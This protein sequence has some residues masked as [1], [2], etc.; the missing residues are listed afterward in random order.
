[1]LPEDYENPVDEQINRIDAWLK[2]TGMKESRLGLLACANARAV[3]R[4]RSGTGSVE[5]LRQLVEYIDAHPLKS[6]KR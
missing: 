3:E 4:V 1:M 5:S 6:M 2:A